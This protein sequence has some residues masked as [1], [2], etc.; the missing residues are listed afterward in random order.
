M[1]SQAVMRFTS[2]NN[3]YLPETT[4]Q[5]IAVVRDP[6][7]FMHNRYIQYVPTPYP[8]A[9]WTEVE[10]TQFSRL[11]QS[12]ETVWTDG[13]ARPVN[14]QNRLRHTT[15]TADSIRHDIGWMLG[16]QTIE[17]TNLYQVRPAHMTMATHQLI[18]QIYSDTWTELTTSGN[19]P[20][21]HT[22]TATN[23]A[24]AKLD[25]GTLSNP[26]YA[27]F[28]LYCGELINRVTG[29]VVQITDLVAIMNPKTA[30]LIGVSAEMRQWFA[31]SV[32]ADKVYADPHQAVDRNFGL[33]PVYQGV[34]Q[35]V[36]TKAYTTTA[37]DVTSGTDTPSYSYFVPDNT[38]LVMSRKGGIDSLPGEMPFSSV[39]MF[40]YAG[41]RNK[42]TAQGP[43]EVG[44]GIDS[45]L[46]VESFDDP[47]NRR[48]EGHVS[49]Q[50][51]SKLVAPWTAF[52]CTSAT[53]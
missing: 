40:Y 53:G 29:G 45:L 38:V 47:R 3:G 9:V 44:E 2:A 7:T 33:P 31:N 24:G 1:P 21:G 25:T 16:Y 39:Q 22:D 27:K 34:E 6:K 19:Y 17:N 35:I 10:R 37:Q 26:Y 30:K 51:V 52:Y 46:A 50:Y 49:C 43:Y 32:L 23:V 13:E 28:L 48:V 8:M 14:R 11:L 41:G 5:V 18:N 36:E 20:S 4:K 15:K 42:E 12:G